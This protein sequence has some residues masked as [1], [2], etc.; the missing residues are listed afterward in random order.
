MLIVDIGS[1]AESLPLPAAGGDG[2]ED[3]HIPAGAGEGQAGQKPVR[4][5]K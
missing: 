1:Y 3:G 4:H 5:S 2:G